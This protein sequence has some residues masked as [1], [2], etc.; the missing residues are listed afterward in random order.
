MKLSLPLAFACAAPLLCGP[1]AVQANDVAAP[2][3]D[4]RPIVLAQATQQSKPALSAQCR[5]DQ[6]RR[7]NTVEGKQKCA[8]V[9]KGKS[10]RAMKGKPQTLIHGSDNP[11]GRY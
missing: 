8:C 1:L 10:P 11:G 2:P 9:P 3:D 4:R 6:V 5:E 7:C